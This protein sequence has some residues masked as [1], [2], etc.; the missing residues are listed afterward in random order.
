MTTFETVA[1]HLCG[2]SEW[3]AAPAPQ[4]GP[5]FVKGAQNPCATLSDDNWLLKPI[6]G[7][8]YQWAYPKPFLS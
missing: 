1:L 4:K 7:A 6:F 8:D 2:P 5:F 3:R